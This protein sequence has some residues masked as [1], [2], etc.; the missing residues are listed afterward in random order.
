MH[1]WIY[2]FLHYK[3]LFKDFI[4]LFIDRDSRKGILGEANLPQY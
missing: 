3:I 1:D 4:P 2:V